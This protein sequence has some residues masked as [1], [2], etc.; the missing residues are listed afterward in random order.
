MVDI[1]VAVNV[2]TGDLTD[3]FKRDLRVSFV[4]QTQLPEIF[5]EKEVPFLSVAHIDY[6]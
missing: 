6:L 4:W 5:S 2:K 1:T 3:S